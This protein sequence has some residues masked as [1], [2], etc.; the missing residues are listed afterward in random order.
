MKVNSR[1]FS[2]LIIIAPDPWSVS[3]ELVNVFLFANSIFKLF[4]M[5]NLIKT[6]KMVQKLLFWRDSK[7]NVPIA[8][9]IEK[10]GRLMSAGESLCFHKKDSS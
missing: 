8:C 6:D 5:R 4:E 10:L 9:A 2:I 3:F 1:E 7:K